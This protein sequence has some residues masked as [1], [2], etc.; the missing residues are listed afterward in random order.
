MSISEAVQVYARSGDAT[1]VREAI[2][3]AWQRPGASVRVVLKIAEGELLLA[4]RNP[5]QVLGCVWR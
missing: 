4:G 3:E 5:R 2:R 1:V